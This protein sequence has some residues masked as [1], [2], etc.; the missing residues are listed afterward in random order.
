MAFIPLFLGAHSKSVL[1]LVL[2]IFFL[3]RQLY[4]HL[5]VQ[6]FSSFRKRLHY[7][8]ILIYIDLKRLQCATVEKLRLDNLCVQRRRVGAHLFRILF[9]DG[10]MLLGR[11]SP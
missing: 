11:L 5:F 6:N 8:S 3:S 1:L 9:G 10:L 7:R 4:H 2:G